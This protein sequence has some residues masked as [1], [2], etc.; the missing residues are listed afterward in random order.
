MDTVPVPKFV[1]QRRSYER[2]SRVTQALLER[3]FP[4]R[5][6][7]KLAKTLTPLIAMAARMEIEARQLRA[8][9][10]MFEETK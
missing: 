7:R 8:C 3:G 4:L 10:K 9:A 2:E 6:A 5:S 1:D